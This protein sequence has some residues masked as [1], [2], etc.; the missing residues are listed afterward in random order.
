[1]KLYH[2][3]RGR[4]FI[5]FTIIV[6]LFFNVFLSAQKRSDKN[7]NKFTGEISLSS[8]YDSNILKYSDKY[9]DR[10]VNNEDEG[11]FHINTY[12]DFVLDY[13]AKILYSNKFLKNLRSLFSLAVE[14][15]QYTS[16]P[17]KSWITYDFDWQQSL[18][19][20]T[21]FLFSYSYLPDFYI[22]HFRDED[23]TKIYGYTPETFRPYSFAKS[24]YSLWIQQVF[25]TKIKS[26][27][28]FSFSRYFY[29][30]NFTEYDSDN[31]I[32]GGKLFSDITDKISID[33]G[34]KYIHSSAKGYDEYFETKAN[35]DDNDATYF[36]HIFS[37]GIEY[38]LPKIF[39]MNNSID[40]STEIG[41]R[42]YTT[43]HTAESDPL[44]SGRD[45]INFRLYFKYDADISK[46]INAGIF[47]NYILRNSDTDIEA[48]KEYV[49]NE[50]D[51]HQ[52]QIGLVFNYRFNF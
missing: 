12:D 24:D 22:S 5:F 31:F 9:L 17:V 49:S 32:A 20:K 52:Y 19:E 30:K 10:F 39:R 4:K 2:L 6:S 43:L 36:E 44:H 1:M 3:I 8:F 25:S 37:V 28:Y 33:G 38:K 16:N 35:S 45:D 13:S 50:K 15:N 48:N 42:H 14:Y 34:Y 40:L 18:S 26:R 23:W 11:R 46:D 29:N 41:A 27:F 51:Y 47:A 21:S 7:E